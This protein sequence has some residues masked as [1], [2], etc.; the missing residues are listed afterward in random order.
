MATTNT[1]TTNETREVKL[2]LHDVESAPEE[3][4]E[5]LEKANRQ[6]GFIPNLWGFQAEAPAL[7]E[8]YQTLSAIFDKSSLS[9]TERQIVLITSSFENECTYCVAAHSG[10]AQA[11]NVPE[12]VIEALRAGTEIE[13]PK[14]EALYQFTG[15]MVRGRGWVSDSET[16]RFLD[17]GYG[18]RH[19]LEVILGVS[20]KVMSNYTN[21]FAQTPLDE[22]WRSLAWTKPAEASVSR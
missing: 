15:A 8:G 6:L 14:L 2:P 9:P 7:L 22:A 18:P 20:L 10:I 5:R 3:S 16:R 11:Q 1:E 12:D 21:H 4:K 17:A 19:I 13:D